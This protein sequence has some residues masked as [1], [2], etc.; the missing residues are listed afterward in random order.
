M[1]KAKNDKKAKSKNPFVKL[2]RNTTLINIIVSVVFLALGVFMVAAPDLFTTVMF[3]VMGIILLLLGAASVVRFIV[4]K[5]KGII[6]YVLL[7]FGVLAIS[8]GVLFLFRLDF[9]VNVV[10]VLLGVYILFTSITTIAQTVSYKREMGIGI[11]IPLILAALGIVCGV[12][13]ILGFLIAQDVIIF[14]T[15]IVLIVYEVLGIAVTVY[16][17]IKRRQIKKAS[18]DIINAEVVE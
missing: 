4:A 6:E 14:F 16:L 17:A 12:L 13:C 2:A 10:S 9:I 1:S 3:I 5:D 18:A 11:L 7:L 15:G 8:G